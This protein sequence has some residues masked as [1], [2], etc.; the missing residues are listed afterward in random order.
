VEE[1]ESEIVLERERERVWVLET[2][3][4]ER[5]FFVCEWGRVAG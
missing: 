4:L 2:E 5:K 1:S 3:K